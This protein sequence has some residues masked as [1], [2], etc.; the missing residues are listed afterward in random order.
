M[1]E[2]RLCVSGLFLL[3]ALQNTTITSVLFLAHDKLLSTT[4]TLCFFGVED[5]TQIARRFSPK[6]LERPLVYVGEPVSSLK[7][8]S[9]HIRS[10]LGPWSLRL[11]LQ[12]HRYFAG[13]LHPSNERRSSKYHVYCTS[14]IWFMSY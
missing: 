14:S 12:F 6:H 2:C 11:L 1:L 5:K 10:W 9:G 8:Q 3:A 13:Y 7:P 4:N